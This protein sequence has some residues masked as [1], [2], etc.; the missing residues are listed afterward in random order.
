MI[1]AS[2]VNGNDKHSLRFWLLVLTQTSQLYSSN[3]QYNSRRRSRTG[4]PCADGTAGASAHGAHVDFELYGVRG[5]SFSYDAMEGPPKLLP[6]Y[7]KVFTTGSV[8]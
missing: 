7:T 4:T 8:S 1:E 5:I 2:S 3:L 6:N